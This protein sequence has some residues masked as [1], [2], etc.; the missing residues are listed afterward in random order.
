M[1]QLNHKHLLVKATVS[2]PIKEEKDLIIWFYELCKKVN[3]KVVCG[4]T[5]KHVPSEGKEGL[6]GSVNIETSHSSI[7]I[8]EATSPPYVQLDLYSCSDFEVK[9]VLDHLNQM[10]ILNAHWLLIDRND[11]TMKVIKEGTYLDYVTC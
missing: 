1:T 9:T 2:L 3:M 10:R 7:H 5:V 6:T 8:W 4:P 11:D